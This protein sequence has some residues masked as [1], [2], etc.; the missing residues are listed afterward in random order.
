ML[1]CVQLFANTRT[2]A[3][4]APLS[5]RFSRKEY[6]SGLPFPSPGDHPNT[7]IEPG[8][9][10]LQADSLLSE[11]PGKSQTWYKLTY[12]IQT[13]TQ[14]GELY[15]LQFTNGE[16]RARRLSNSFKVTQ[17]S[18]WELDLG[19][20][21]LC[22]WKLRSPASWW[23]NRDFRRIYPRCQVL[24]T[25]PLLGSS[26][27]ISTSSPSTS[28]ACVHAS[29]LWSSLFVLFWIFYCGKIFVT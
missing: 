11:S 26:S 8:S 16:N 20:H 22:S 18:K 12:P 13:K 2:V 14:G 3:H 24:P 25:V 17:V 21:S 27:Q 1:S 19:S 23:E 5:M 28:R 15:C 6:W 7:G 29:A 10:A 9:P 4:Q